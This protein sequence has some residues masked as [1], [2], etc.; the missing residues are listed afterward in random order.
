[1]IA[2]AQRCSN[3]VDPTVYRMMTVKGAFIVL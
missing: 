1:M 2:M 3:Y